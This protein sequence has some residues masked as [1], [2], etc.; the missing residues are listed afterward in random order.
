MHVVTY[1]R[2]YGSLANAA[3]H[4]E[5]LAVLGF[6]FEIAPE[7]NLAWAPL[8]NSLPRVTDPTTEFDLKE[9]PLAKLLPD[10]ISEYYR[11]DGGLTTPPCSEVVTWTVFRQPIRI[12]A[13]QMAAFRKL[14]SSDLDPAGNALPLV[15]NFRPV[16]D[17]HG[18]TISTNF[19]AT[20]MIG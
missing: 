15:D 12:S 3:R 17:L 9:V 19:R 11:Y 4:P 13:K 20:M 2:F 8:I 14:K 6:F 7:E 16:Q 10:D 5:G 1:D 18:R